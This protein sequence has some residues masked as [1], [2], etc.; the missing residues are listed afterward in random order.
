MLRISEYMRDSLC[1]KPIRKTDLVIL[2]WNLTNICNLF[3][4]HCYANAHAQKDEELTLEEIEAAF[5]DLWEKGVRFIILS[6]GEPLVRKDIFVIAEKMRAFG[7]IT[8]LSSNGLLIHQE[9]IS[10]IKRHF[11]YVGISIDGRP[12]IHDKFRLKKGAF[13]RSIKAIELCRDAGIRV[14]MRYTLTKMTLDSLGFILDLV[15]ELNLPK[16]YISHLVYA[17]RAQASLDLSHQEYLAAMEQILDRAFRWLEQ[18]VECDLVTGNNEADA[19]FL[20]DAFSKRYPSYHDLLARRLL[21]WGGNQ[22]GKRLVNI[23]HRGEVKP[24]PFFPISLGNLREH[25]FSEIWEG[26]PERRGLLQALRM[27]PRSLKGKCQ[28]CSSL[29][30]CNGSSRVRAKALHDDYFAEDPS[31]ALVV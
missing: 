21:L 14:G 16:L 3:C 1:E 18:G 29:L 9:N 10:T 17:G 31:C 22:A 25:R 30:F 23:N 4:E 27:S 28:S 13:E 11:H 20:L 7:F 24:D 2:I 12:E 19:R 6:G 15:E 5:P 8:Y 26:L